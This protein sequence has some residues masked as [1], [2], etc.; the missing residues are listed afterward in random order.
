MSTQVPQALAL[1]PLLSLTYINDLG[2]C[3]K[4]SKTYHFPDDTSWQGDCNSYQ[5]AK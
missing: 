1:G 4:Y 5:V 2:K 3:R